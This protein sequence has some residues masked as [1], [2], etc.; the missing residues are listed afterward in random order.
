MSLFEKINLTDNEAKRIIYNTYEKV[1][2]AL[3]NK[4]I[5]EFGYSEKEMDYFGK[6][7]MN[8]DG[9]AAKVFGAK[10]YKVS[11]KAEP[12][13]LGYIIGEKVLMVFNN[14]GRGIFE[15]T[16]QVN[17]SKQVKKRYG[18]GMDSFAM[19]KKDN[20]WQLI[21]PFKE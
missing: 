19:C 21:F 13:D 14:N 9:Y 8:I 16:S 1:L 10:D 2:N 4:N 17:E 20:A 5:S 7:L 3:K 11:A 6:R 15:V 12:Q 18:Y